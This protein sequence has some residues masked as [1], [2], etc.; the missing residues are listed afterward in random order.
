MTCHSIWSSGFWCRR[1]VSLRL[2]ALSF[3]RTLIATSGTDSEF[4]APLTSHFTGDYAQGSCRDPSVLVQPMRFSSHIGELAPRQYAF[5][6]EDACTKT[7]RFWRTAAA[8]HN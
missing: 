6:S 8:V 3:V 2:Q 1:G 7:I 5:A 4:F